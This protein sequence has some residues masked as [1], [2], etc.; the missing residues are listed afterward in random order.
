LNPDIEGDEE[1]KKSR[2]TLLLVDDHPLVREGLRS[3]LVQQKTFDIVGEAIDG[4][5]ALREAKS[6]LP[7]IILLDIN[8]PGMNGLET[9]RLLKKTV[10]KSKILIL[11]MHD[12]KEYISRMVSTGVQGYVLKDSSP[13]ELI[14][15]IEAVHRGEKYFSQKISQTVVNDYA[16]IVRSKGKKGSVELSRRESEVLA[17]IAEGMGNKEIAGRL[18]V[19]VRTVE[20]HRERIIR[21]LDI[22]TIAGLTRYALTKGIVK[23][24]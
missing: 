21:K 5:E 9:A 24:E 1:V 16:K 17:L 22:H 18:F 13:S 14:A 19:S 10:P 6:L 23:L 4:Q 2:I 15:A 20:T 11:T 3:C 7:E 8:M 12:S